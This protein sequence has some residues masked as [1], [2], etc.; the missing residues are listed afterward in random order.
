MRF[1]G[2]GR[3]QSPTAPEAPAT[4]STHDRHAVP[5]A[6]S[7]QEIVVY[8]TTDGSRCRQVRAILEKYGHAYKDVRVDDDLST[9]SWLQRA[10][11]DDALPKVFVGT[12][13]YGG[14]EDIQ[15]LA[16]D[17][18]LDQIVRGEVPQDHHDDDSTTL[19]N[20]MSAASIIALWH[21]G[22]I[23][24]IREGEMETDAWAERLA[25]PPSVY[26]EGSPHPLAE[27]Q[28]IAEHIVTRLKNG[29]IEVRWKGE[30]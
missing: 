25:N 5:T 8:G 13:C 1:W 10:T 22:E 21:R 9:R 27:L 23:L 29:E 30:D 20:D 19:K 26:Y 15:V 18:R 7:A 28:Q 2:F 17:G 11:G 6:S 3:K 24:T 16:F 12:R 4:S 14:F